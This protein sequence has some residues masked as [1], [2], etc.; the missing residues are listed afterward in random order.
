MSKISQLEEKLAFQIRATGL[1]EPVRE[2]RFVPGRLY[3]ADFAWPNHKLLVEAEGGVFSRKGKG[4]GWH[5]SVGGYLDD[6]RKYTLAALHGWRVLR[7]TAPEIRN[8]TA[9]NEIEVA[10]R[11][12]IQKPQQM[13]MER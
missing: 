12:G 11:G 3:R 1:P 8:G 10:L 5:Q 4:G 7:Y 6:C 2:Y 13:E 9:I